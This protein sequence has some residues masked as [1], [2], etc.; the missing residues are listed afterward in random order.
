MILAGNDEFNKLFLLVFVGVTVIATLITCIK[1]F[2]RNKKIEKQN[3]KIMH[4]EKFL[5]D[6]TS[7][8]KKK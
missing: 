6:E 2:G 5:D 3:E 4:D 8:I 1:I 7:I